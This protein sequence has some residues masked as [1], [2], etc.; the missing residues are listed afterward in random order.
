VLL[1]TR[2]EG[3]W[4]GALALNRLLMSRRS[5]RPLLV[6]RGR[7]AQLGALPRPE[8]APVSTGKL[9]T[10]ARGIALQAVSSRGKALRRSAD[11][12]MT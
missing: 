6:S 8:F 3:T 5:A 11:V 1:I 10:S 7:L 9:S 4:L 2:A 12:S